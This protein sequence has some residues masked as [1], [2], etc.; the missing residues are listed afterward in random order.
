MKVL[1]HRLRLYREDLAVSG[2]HERC[3]SN[4]T[5][6]IDYTERIWR[7]QDNWKTIQTLINREIIPRGFGGIRT[8][9]R[10]ELSWKNVSKDYT[11]RI[12]RYQDNEDNRFGVFL[13]YFG[14]YREDLAVSGQRKEILSTI[15]HVGL[16]REDLAVSGQHIP[17]YF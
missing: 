4:N 13:Y 7:Y 9:D 12:W 16:Y 5:P 17:E 10:S 6:A 14:L 15:E 11:E 3:S 8:T 1:I 2:Q